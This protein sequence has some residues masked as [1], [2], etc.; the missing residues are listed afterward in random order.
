M[1]RPGFNDIFRRCLADLGSAFATGRATVRISPL[2]HVEY[3]TNKMPPKAA[4]PVGQSGYSYSIERILQEK[5]TPPRRV[6]L[7]RYVLLK[8]NC[9]TIHLLTPADPAPET[10]NLY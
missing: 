7:A 4:G 1:Q 2:Y 5:E 10:T 6:Y 9:Q 8:L 3:H